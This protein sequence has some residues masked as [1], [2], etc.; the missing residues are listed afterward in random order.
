MAPNTQ[1][2][3]QRL[4]H[5]NRTL[6]ANIEIP[7]SLE[8]K[9]YLIFTKKWMFMFLRKNIKFCWKICIWLLAQHSTVIHNKQYTTQ[10][11]IH[12]TKYIVGFIISFETK[13]FFGEMVC[14]SW[15]GL[16]TGGSWTVCWQWQMISLL[17][18]DVWFWND[19]SHCEIRGQRPMDIW[20]Y[21]VGDRM[22]RTLPARLPE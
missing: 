2:L 18:D 4:G 14:L 13:A 21:K 10:Q 17:T 11:T 20:Y 5:I 6:H 9:N 7:T 19:D 15:I 16:G 22:P 12:N 3:H 1:R 8:K